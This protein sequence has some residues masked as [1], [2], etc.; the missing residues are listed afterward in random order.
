MLTAAAFGIYLLGRAV[1]L[2][3]CAAALLFVADAFGER[4]R[5]LVQVRGSER[6]QFLMIE[7][8]FDALG[9]ARPLGLGQI[10]GT[11][12]QDEALAWAFI[13][14]YRL[15]EAVIGVGA[16]V[17]GELE[18]TDEHAPARYQRGEDESTPCSYQNVAPCEL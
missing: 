14:A 16:T 8:I 17:A 2:L 13:G 12:A 1:S 6:N 4:C 9:Q 7:Q 18:L 15:Q 10:E 3:L 5:Q 11:E